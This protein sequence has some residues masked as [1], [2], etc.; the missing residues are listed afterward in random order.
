MMSFLLRVF[1]L[2]LWDIFANMKI[3]ERKLNATE[4]DNLDLI[5]EYEKEEGYR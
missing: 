3:E 1:M 4:L 5:M 2:I